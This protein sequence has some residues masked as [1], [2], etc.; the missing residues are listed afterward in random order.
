MITSMRML[1]L[2]LLYVIDPSAIISL[3]ECAIYSDTS[4][5]NGASRPQCQGS[6]WIT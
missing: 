4:E 1:V 5:Y 3:A 2:P 6:P